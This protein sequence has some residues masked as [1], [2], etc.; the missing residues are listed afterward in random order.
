VYVVG[1]P[2]AGCRGGGSIGPV[3][4]GGGG[5]GRIGDGLLGSVGVDGGDR[6]VEAGLVGTGLVVADDDAEPLIGKRSG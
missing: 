1:G 2:A 6:N 4:A 3:R 5:G